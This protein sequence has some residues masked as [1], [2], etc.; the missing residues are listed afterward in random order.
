VS[1]PE[2]PY[3]PPDGDDPDEFEDY[4]E[5]ELKEF[6]ELNR[7]TATTTFLE[8]RWFRMAAVGIV[9]LVVLSFLVPVLAPFIN[10]LGGEDTPHSN[11][12]TLPDFVLPAAY[13]D[14]VRL[15]DEVARNDVVVI[16]FYR[17]FF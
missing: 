7:S 15:S 8:A 14:D 3:D 9:A 2:T 13:G 16:V 6:D 11:A 5:H 4:D 12:L 1:L 17:G 10:G